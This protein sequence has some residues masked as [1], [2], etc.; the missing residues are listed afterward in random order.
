MGWI[1]TN[2][3]TRLTGSTND[4]V[5]WLKTTLSWVTVYHQKLRC[6]QWDLVDFYLSVGERQHPKSLASCKVRIY[7][8]STLLHLWRRWQ[9]KQVRS[10]TFDTL[11]LVQQNQHRPWLA[12]KLVENDKD[13]PDVNVILDPGLN[14]HSYI[15]ILPTKHKICKKFFPMKE[16]SNMVLWRSVWMPGLTNWYRFR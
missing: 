5:I 14:F 9:L 16:T 4:M 7:T 3:V 11:T 2:C 15:G 10:L 6:I 1:F 13:V 8:V 12:R